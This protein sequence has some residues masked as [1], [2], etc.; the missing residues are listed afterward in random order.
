MS[1]VEIYNS[2]PNLILT[3]IQD[4]STRTVTPENEQLPQHLPLFFIFSEKGNPDD[5]HV[6]GTNSFI[7]TYGNGFIDYAS[8]YATHASPFVKGI[9]EENNLIMV[10]RLKPQGASTAWLRFSLGLL[11]QELVDSRLPT[12]EEREAK[13]SRIVN[14]RI[15]ESRGYEGWTL[16]WIVGTPNT[17]EYDLSS[18]DE[19]NRKIIED[20]STFGKALTVSQL[21]TLDGQ[22]TE[23]STGISVGYS[24]RSANKNGELVQER[25]YPMFD[26]EVTDFGDY[27]NNLGIRLW[28]PNNFDTS[29]PDNTFFE[30]TLIREYRAAMVRRKNKRTTSTVWKNILGEDVT[31]FVFKPE[32]TNVLSNN[33]DIYLETRLLENYRNLDNTNGRVPT[34]GPFNRVKAYEEN[35]RHVM[36]T[37]FAEEQKYEAANSVETEYDMVNGH[38]VMRAIEKGKVRHGLEPDTHSEAP[39]LYRPDIADDEVLLDN[40]KWQLDIFTGLTVNG[41]AY[42]TFKVLD[43][44]NDATHTVVKQMTQNTEHFASGGADGEMG[45]HEYNRL[46]AE[47]IDLMTNEYSYWNDL[48]RYPWSEFYDSGY[49]IYVKDKFAELMR[50]RKDIAVTAATHYVADYEPGRKLTRVSTVREGVVPLSREEEVGAV[51][52]LWTSLTRYP[53]SE[54][55]GTKSCRANIIMQC[56]TIIGSDYKGLVPL[57]YELAIKRARF[58]GDRNGAMRS[59]YGYD[60]PEMKKLQFMKEVNNTFVPYV[61]RERNWT[62]GAT[63]AQFFDR[64]TMFFPA[65]RTVYKDETSVL[66]SDIN[67]HIAVDLE[68][69]CFRVWRHLVGNT[70]LT[71]AQFIEES[72]RKIIEETDGRYDARTVIKPETYYTKGDEQRGYSWNCKIHAYLN[73]MKT[74]GVFTVVT[75]RQEDLEA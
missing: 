54:V 39:R 63:W 34:Y 1:S 11:K 4:L 27:G 57:T 64:R 9:M 40:Q 7:A 10:Q 14:G 72:D 22:E 62:H 60:Q 24:P 45:I 15:H 19:R 74:V 17:K 26:L 32:T 73:N 5:V 29:K 37:L 61:Q 65:V 16:R 35:I 31:N 23:L 21:G 18:F 2:T 58:M 53:E 8:K 44:Y 20:A 71:N 68:K 25:I 6:V 55:Y 50:A 30:N 75:H 70:K 48:A 41:F 12:T 36:E 28:C 49:P 52:T 56:G 42:R 38:S 3:G 69:V 46:V 67:M 66:I 33:D 47:K 43:M 59:G 13:D 51:R